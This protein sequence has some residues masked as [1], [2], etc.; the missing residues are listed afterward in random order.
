MWQ[1][2]LLLVNSELIAVVKVASVRVPGETIQPRWFSWRDLNGEEVWAEIREAE[3]GAWEALTSSR[4][5]G[6]PRGRALQAVGPLAGAVLIV[7]QGVAR[8]GHWSRKVGGRSA[9]G[10]VSPHPPLSGQRE[11][12]WERRLVVQAAE[13]SFPGCRAADRFGGLQLET[14]LHNNQLSYS[15]HILFSVNFRKCYFGEPWEI[16]QP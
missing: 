11:A 3:R 7:A 4:A 12:S 5:E 2:I 13:V 1:K 10:S 14:S 9:P 15:Q 16:V 8:P 6:A